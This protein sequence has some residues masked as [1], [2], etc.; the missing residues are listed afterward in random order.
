MD[1]HDRLHW[2]ARAPS[3][4]APCGGVFRTPVEIVGE[5]LRTHTIRS[6]IDVDELG[7]RSSLADSLH[8][9][10]KR[11][12]D[13]DDRV[14][15]TDPGRHQ[16]KANGIGPVRNTDAVIGPAIFGKLSFERLDFGTT[17]ESSGTE[18]FSKR[19]DELTLELAMRSSEIKERNGLKTGHDTARLHA[20][21][22][23]KGPTFV[24]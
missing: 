19:L 24:S 12:R 6:R 5:R 1:W 2:L 4:R 3:D 10:D 16:R 20:I 8:R 7:L 13:G 14:A 22:R 21:W 9:R 17:D 23:T 11:V 15:L 18:R